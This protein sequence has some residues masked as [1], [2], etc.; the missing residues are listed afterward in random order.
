MDNRALVQQGLLNL[1]FSP[2]ATS[3]IMA[4]AYHESGADYSPTRLQGGG[5]A[6]EVNVDGET[7]Y[8]LFQWTSS[9]RQ[10]GL[11]DYAKQAGTSSSDL[12]T[13]L[14]YMKKELGQEGFNKINAMTPEDAALYFNDYYE[15]PA[16]NPENRLA[17]KN[18][19]TTISNTIGQDGG[20]TIVDN[21]DGIKTNMVTENPNEKLDME[22]VM[23][24]IQQPKR[25]VAAAGEEALREQ[26]VRQAHHRARGVFASRFYE[27]SDKA[28]M[29]AAVAKAQ[30]EA[31]L[32]NANAQLTG[33]GKLAQMIA[34]SQNNSNR[35]AYASLGAMVGM[36]VNPMQ[37]QLM[38][39]NQL[40]QMGLQ[41]QLQRKQQEEQMQRQ[42]EMMLLS[43]ATRPH[44]GGGGSGSS[45][46]GRS[47]SGAKRTMSP[48][49][50]T[51][52]VDDIRNG[53]REVLENNAN[54]GSFSQHDVDNL[55]EQAMLSLQKLAVAEDDPYAV[56]TVNDIKRW[57]SE[58]LKHMAESQSGHNLKYD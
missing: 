24:I 57:Q 50:N 33:A 34:N 41:V 45:G 31:K 47:S 17:R 21:I 1:G 18:M 42:K 49:Q 30:E 46:S 39:H 54:L 25:N 16:Y 52:Y 9:D 3:G 26:L 44:G 43:A 28:M 38:S 53:F 7:G 51:K 58:Q 48:A 56:Q 37:T 8:G 29:N 10:Q 11:A 23:S 35:Q 22:G 19:A 15:R 5:E 14:S 13:Q 27:D 2:G 32:Q 20:K 12:L 40:A 55:N 4:N 36:N 6:G